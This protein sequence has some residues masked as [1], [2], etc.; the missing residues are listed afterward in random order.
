MVLCKHFGKKDING[1]TQHR[2]GPMAQQWYEGYGGNQLLSN[3][4][5]GLLQESIHTLY[6]KPGQKPMDWEVKGET[7]TVI[8][9][10]KHVTKLL[11]RYLC[12]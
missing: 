3:R 11:P 2:M 12:L 8:L 4:L 1:L 5:S 10:N 6:C 7:I 9:L